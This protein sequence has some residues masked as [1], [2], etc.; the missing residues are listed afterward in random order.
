M[1]QEKRIAKF[2]SSKISKLCGSL[3]SGEPSRAF[4]TY[5]DDVRLEQTIK[6]SVD[7]D[8]NSMPL[9][10]GSLMEVV[11]FQKNQIGLSYRMMHKMTIVHDEIENY[12]GTPDFLELGE[13]VAEVKCLYP[14]KFAALSLCLQKKNIAL[15]KNEFPEVYWQVVSNSILTEVENAEIIVYMPYKSEL[16]EI[17]GKIEETN[18]LESNNLNPSDYYFMTHNDIETLP[19]LPDDCGFPNI[20]RFKFKV[21]EEDVDFLISRIKKANEILK[22]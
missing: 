19:Y 15:L 9:K 1:E 6:R 5:I 7:V 22:Q 12:S 20:N 10:W 18:L 16:E 21:P 14:R 11:L 13:C 4:Y 3:K 8:V 17:I 2:T